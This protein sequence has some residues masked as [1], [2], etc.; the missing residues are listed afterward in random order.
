MTL[1]LQPGLADVAVSMVWSVARQRYCF[2]GGWSM[3][4]NW[5]VLKAVV[6]PRSVAEACRVRA[7]QSNA[8]EAAEIWAAGCGLC[9]ERCK[10]MLVYEHSRST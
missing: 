3:R 5:H 1:C 10:V 7:Q 9:C 6:Q 4:W 8:S 2:D